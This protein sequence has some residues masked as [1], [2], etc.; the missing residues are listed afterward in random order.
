MSGTR[1]IA[2]PILAS[3]CLKDDIAP[4]EPFALGGRIA[5]G[6]SGLGLAAS[7]LLF[8]KLPNVA[9]AAGASAFALIGAALPRYAL[10]AAAALAAAVVTTMMFV[11]SPSIV[12]RVVGTGLLASALFLRATYRAHGATRVALGLGLALFVFSGIGTGRHS[13]IGIGVVAA[14]SLLGFMNDQTTGG[15]AFWG[16]LAIAVATG[17]IA[18]SQPGVPTIVA[19]GLAIVCAAIGGFQLAASFIADD[20]RKREHR[21]SLPPP[22]SNDSE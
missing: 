19:A 10:R 6:V 2:K 20:E 15:C 16:A 9:I 17:S 5:Y 13:G 3:E 1:P 21:L 12:L 8:A 22:P 4:L 14:A 18:L 7:A 11:S